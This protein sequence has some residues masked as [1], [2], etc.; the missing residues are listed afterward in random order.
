MADRVFDEL[1]R[2]D[3]AATAAEALEV[4][5]VWVIDKHLQCTINA[6]V[7]ADHGQWGVFL[8]DLA[9]HVATALHRT[10]GVDGTEALAQIIDRFQRELFEQNE[11]REASP[12]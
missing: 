2:P 1:D 8:S 6:G 7:F 5:R 9:H 3:D 10:H 4:V 11:A 12:G